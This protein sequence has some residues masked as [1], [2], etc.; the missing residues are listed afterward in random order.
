MPHLFGL[1]TFLVV[2][3]I[4]FFSPIAVSRANAD[5]ITV[6]SGQFVLPWDDPSYFSFFGAGLVLRGGF[7]STPTSPWR[8]CFS[9]C[10]PGT[11]LDMGAMAGGASPFTRFP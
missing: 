2:G 6:T 4:A 9:G 8:T 3:F 7:V 1:R 11:A 5:T 10:I